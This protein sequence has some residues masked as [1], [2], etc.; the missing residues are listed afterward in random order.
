[1]KYPYER[2]TSR[3]VNLTS[4][5]LI[6]AFP[7]LCKHIK[8]QRLE[9][10]STLSLV[11]IGLSHG[12]LRF[13]VL[14]VKSFNWINEI[15]FVFPR[16][17]SCVVFIYCLRHAVAATAASNE[18]KLINLLQAS[19]IAFCVRCL[20]MIRSLVIPRLLVRLKRFRS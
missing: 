2:N 17:E 5:I 16:R 8:S 6:F 9:S 7:S 12:D 15:Q 10:L 4:Q 11:A 1:M 18:V 14:I 3:K 13:F 19:R 20:L